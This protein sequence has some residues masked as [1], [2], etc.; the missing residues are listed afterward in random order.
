MVVGARQ[1]FQFFRQYT[2]FLKS[3]R[4]LYKFLCRILHF[5]ISITKLSKKSVHKSQL[6]I[7]HASHPNTWLVSD[8]EPLKLELRTL[9][10][11]YVELWY[12]HKPFTH[13]WA[14]WWRLQFQCVS[15][16]DFFNRNLFESAT[17]N[18]CSKVILRLFTKRFFKVIFRLYLD[19][20]LYNIAHVYWLCYWYCWTHINFSYH[21]LVS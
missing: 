6:Y 1:N 21:V 11:S 7:N 13:C 16:T 18:M 19:G 3:K 5:L 15:V 8:Q 4:T 14:D 12:E 10:W 17:N 9:P 2:W 20:K